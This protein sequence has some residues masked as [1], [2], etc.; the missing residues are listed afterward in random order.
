MKVV[1]FNGSPNREGNTWQALKIVTDVLNSRGVE[2]EIIH[3]GGSPVK[4]C[5]ACGMCGRNKDERCVQ[6]DDPVNDWI[7]LIKQADGLLLGSP[8]HY[9]GIAAGLKAFLDRAF[10]VQGS[11]G[12][13]FRHKAGAALVAV[14]HSGGVGCFNELNNYLTCSEML[15][16]GSNYWNVIHGA[17]PGE[18]L[19]DTE[20]V[21]TLQILGENMVWL[22]Y[23]ISGTRGNLDEPEKKVKQFMNF[24]R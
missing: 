8:V 21:Q 6:A 17:K 12:R 16:P 23:M 7:Q 5:A 18:V 11:N 19:Q 14:R 2:T 13:L 15:I 10:F 22:L 3:V 24:I 20:G 9:A 4:A 1:A